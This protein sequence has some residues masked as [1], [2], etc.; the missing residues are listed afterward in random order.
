MRHGETS[1][2]AEYC[3]RKNARIAAGIDENALSPAEVKQREIEH[4]N[5][6]M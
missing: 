1:Y 6:A 2:I 3:E 5:H 4:N